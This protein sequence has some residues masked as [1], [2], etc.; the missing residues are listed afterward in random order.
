MLN[1]R[2][3]VITKKKSSQK[4]GSRILLFDIFFYC[5]NMLE[6]RDQKGVTKSEFNKTHC[7]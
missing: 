1:K 7:F 3:V 4:A 5:L 2:L 6:I